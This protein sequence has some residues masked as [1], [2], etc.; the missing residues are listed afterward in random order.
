MLFK[1]FSFKECFV[2]KD[3][4]PDVNFYHYVFMLDSL[5][6]DKF[7]AYFKDFSKNSFS[8]LHLNIRSI[9]KNLEAV[10]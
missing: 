3:Y 7:K 2:G 1:P 4:C 6:P 5:T 10:T 9:N 8:V